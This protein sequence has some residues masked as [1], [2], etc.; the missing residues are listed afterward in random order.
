MLKM[1]MLGCLLVCGSVYA[2]FNGGDDFDDSS[3]DLG[4]WMTNAVHD[5]GS[6]LAEANGRLEFVSDIEEADVDRTSAWLW[7]GSGGSYTQ[8]WTVICTAFSSLD[9][10]S[11]T[12]GE[13]WAGL[14]VSDDASTLENSASIEMRKGGGVDTVVYEGYTAEESVL[15]FGTPVS[16]SRVVLQLAFDALT[17]TIAFSYKTADGFINRS[18]LDVSGWGM[19]DSNEFDVAVYAGNTGLRV[20]SGQLYLDEFVLDPSAEGFDSDGDG[21]PNEYELQYTGS[22]TAMDPDEDW[23]GDGQDHLMEYTYAT[24]PTHAESWF[25]GVD[26]TAARGQVTL[27]WTT[28][29]TRL[30]WTEEPTNRF[31]TVYGSSNLNAGFQVLASDLIEVS[32]YTDTVY[33][34]G[35]QAF[36]S[37]GVGVYPPLYGLDLAL[38]VNGSVDEDSSHR[39]QSSSLYVARSTVKPSSQYFTHAVAY[40][41]L[42]SDGFTD[43]LA[44]SGDGSS[45]ATPV[46][47]YLNDGS[48]GFAPDAS[49]F[50]GT[51]PAL[52]HPRKAL[53][54]DYNGDGQMDVFIAGH[55]YDVPPYDGEA[56][57]IVLSSDSGYT[58]FAFSDLA[59][60]HHGAASADIDADGDLD[61]FMTDSLFGVFL[62]NDGSGGFTADSA[63]LVGLNSGELFTAELVD[64]DQDGYVDLLCG[65]HEQNGYPTRILWGDRTGVYKIQESTELP[66][67]AGNGVV[68]D[69]DAA[70]LDGDGDRDLAVN[71]TGDGSGALG[72]YE[73]YYVQLI[74]N[75][76]DR[77]F[78]AATGFAM[79]DG[80]DPS[81]GWFD[82][83]VLKDVNAD[84]SIDLAADDAAAGLIWTNSPN[85]FFRQ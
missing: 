81:G 28:M 83:L 38:P 6:V 22:P 8:D 33:S 35:S 36:Y 47:V 7:I 69:I 57:W 37:L 14:A 59:G 26:F 34:A 31:F 10:A 73:G 52:V 42:N 19:A 65:G 20:A 48:G 64:V 55:G 30:G 29:S 1:K 3:P 12:N 66:A 85:G 46:Q 76:G 44:A 40:A 79:N 24:L 11:I 70:D 67:A 32:A 25:P 18:T 82:W 16:S 45:N 2:N 43:I 51:V 74:Q 72:F 9:A 84:G 56:P 63:R 13:C 54:G 62:I 23:D 39:L 27:E 50:S 61:I 49:F 75:T 17:H 80:A 68:L 4:L 5:A 60:F 71:R 53:A 77:T 21:L 41:D 78:I 58:A 15:E